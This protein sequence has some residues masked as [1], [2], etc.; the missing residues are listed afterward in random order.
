L[1]L[2]GFCGAEKIRGKGKDESNGKGKGC[3]LWDGLLPAHHKVHAM[4]GVPVLLWLAE[5]DRQGQLQRQEQ[6]Q[7]QERVVL[8][9]TG[10]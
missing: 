2:N 10:C 5:E 8:A 6:R 9:F 1:V 7:R 4:D 3:R